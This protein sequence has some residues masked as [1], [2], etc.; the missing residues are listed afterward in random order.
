MADFW[1][2]IFFYKNYFYLKFNF[3]QKMYLDKLSKTNF[4]NPFEYHCGKLYMWPELLIVLCSI[5]FNNS[6]SFDIGK[7]LAE[8]GVQ[9]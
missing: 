5:L 1:K 6:T 2:A 3:R 9:Y 8:R 4:R 7:P